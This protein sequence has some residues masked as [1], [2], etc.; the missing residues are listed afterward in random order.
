M[1]ISSSLKG[2]SGHLETF[3]LM[4][5]AATSVATSGLAF[6]I[7]GNPRLSA[8]EVSLSRGLLGDILNFRNF[9]EMLVCLKKDVD[10][11]I[12]WID[13]GLGLGVVGYVVV[14][15]KAI[16]ASLSILGL[17]P[18]AHFVPNPKGKALMGSGVTRA[19]FSLKPTMAQ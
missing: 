6:G 15:S 11:C 2:F 7:V 1:V 4:G 3:A 17:P 16:L 14:E 12:M 18:P 5:Q 13:S 9:I 10:Q 8:D 19:K